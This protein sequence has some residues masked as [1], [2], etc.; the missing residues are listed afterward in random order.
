MWRFSFRQIHGRLLGRISRA[1]DRSM[2]ALGRALF[3]D[4]G[5]AIL[6]FGALVHHPALQQ[7]GL[8]ALEELRSYG[9]SIP[10]ADDPVRIYPAGTT[11]SVT[12]FHAGGWRPGVISLREN[13]QG[14]AGAE[15]YLRH[16][17]M[18]EA[19]FR[20][21]NGKLP[22]W[23]EEAAAMRFSGELALQITVNQPNQSDMETLQRRIRW[24]AKLNKQDYRTLSS[25][26]ALHGWPQ[27]PCGISE[28][29]EKQLAVQRPDEDAAFSYT[30]IHL[31]SGRTV[32]SKGDTRS[33][34]P[35][36]SL[37][38]IPYAAALKEGV[39]SSIGEE[40]A[41]SDTTRL[42]QRKGSF[43]LGVFRRIVSIVRDA[44]LGQDVPTAE[45]QGKGDGFWRQYLGERSEDGLFPLEAN[46]A[47]LVLVL[48]SSLLYRPQYFEGL[49]LNGFVETSTLYGQ[50]EQDKR[51]LGQLQALSKTGTVSD[52]R[53]TPLVGHLMVA[54]P[55]GNPAYLAVFRSLGV[56]GAA[57]L[58]RAAQVLDAWA[59]RFP[60]DSGKVRVRLMSLV[61]RGSWEIMDEC[62]SLS[63][64]DDQGRKRRIST[65]GKFRI[66]SSA[67]GSRSERL[68]SGILESSP[69]DQTVVLETDPETYADGVLHAEAADLRG[70]AR[71]ALQAVI[72]WNATR[73]SIRHVDS[74]ALCD[75]THCM[76]FQGEIPGRNQRHAT[77]VDQALLGW[78]DKLSREREL[79]WLPFSKGGTDEWRRTI[80]VSEL[81]RL[82]AEPAVLD[83]RRERTRKGDVVV[84]IVYPENEE[85]IPCDHF[86]NRL[87]LY[88]CPESI[89]H[90]PDSD[91]WIFAG[92]GEGHGEGLATE[93]ARAMSS[94]G[95]NALSILVDAYRE[96]KWTK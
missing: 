59:Q 30:L 21:C 44:P 43:D 47:E 60:T 46:L 74:G 86:R 66:L 78:L 42:L 81:R 93:R 37:L 38:K 15:V 52:T 11:G 84:H 25:L 27:K 13:P 32:E 40:L 17:L 10:T 67:R 87:K 69:D 22:P 89:R 29:L 34:F 1:G 5:A 36:G 90:E 76:V 48:R 16:E 4:L 95:R 80:S 94:A 31:L 49:A 18:H 65:C 8:Q 88:S 85:L 72:V 55:A 96:E 63:F 41:A 50:S 19:S 51:V 71:K 33:P 23:A 26:V 91:S 82:V 3:L 77:P 20:T 28:D 83:I 75:S 39:G 7:C 35:P 61:P 68:V 58:H 57:N 6:I 73:G 92:V 79:G 53:G 24:G 9:Y 2:K 64:E 70:E 12:A 56:N 62:P 14:P 45:L 54:W